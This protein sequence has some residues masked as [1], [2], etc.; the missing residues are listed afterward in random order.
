M[1]GR[2]TLL[3]K[4]GCHL[5]REMRAVV[6]AWRDG[7]Y[8]GASEVARRLFEYWFDEDHDVPGFG[9]PFR[10]YFCQRE[11]IE[12]LIYLMENRRLT[13]LS[14]VTAEYGHADPDQAERAVAQDELL[15][16][17]Q[18]LARLHALVAQVVGR[19]P[20]PEAEGVARV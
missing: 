1:A 3:S 17:D 20:G 10:Y 14:K 4:P 6:D 18:Q 16:L 7:G 8:E 2:L 19:F 9:V 15:A 11:A 13:S 12:T 5:C